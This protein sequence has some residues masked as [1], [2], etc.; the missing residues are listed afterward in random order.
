[1]RIRPLRVLI[2]D[3]NKDHQ[4]L[5]KES[6]KGSIQD[7]DI[8]FA[9]TG[10]D[11][12]H[13]LFNET[14]DLLI[15]DF[16]LSDMDGLGVLRN[17]NQKKC[18][19][20]I[21]MVTAFGNE[22]VA[23]EAMKL[24]AYD[25][26][27]KSKGYLR[28]L[29]ATILKVVREY[30]LRNEKKEIEDKLVKSELRYRTLV[31]HIIDV[32][33][34]A[35]KD[36][37][38]LSINSTCQRVFECSIEDAKK[39]GIYKLI[40][41]EDRKR[42][43][44]FFKRS[45]LNKK[46]FIEC[47][48]FRIKTGKGNIKHIELNARANYDE[49][50]ELTQIEGV[51][52]DITERKRFEQKMFQIDKLNALGLQSSGIAHEFNNILGIILGYIDILKLRFEGT[53]LQVSDVIN[54]IEKAARDGAS[55]VDKIQQ[56]SKT[57][58]K[59]SDIICSDLIKVVDE[60]IEFTMP[61]WKSEAQ[62]RGVEY[63]IIN[64]N[65][66]GQRLYVRC[67]PSELREVMVNII[68]N[69][70]DATPNGGKI[71]F[72]AK[73]DAESVV[74][75]IS[76]NGIGIRD[77]IKDKI[78]DPFFSTKG[79][80]RSGLGMSVAYSIITRY[81]GEIDVDSGCG[82]GT[83]VHIKMNSYSSDITKYEKKE[84]LTT[85]YKA[86]ILVIED[87]EVILEMMKIIL[88]KRGHEVFIAKDANDGLSMYENNKYDIVL[89]DLA[90][91]K[92]NGWKVARYIKDLDAVRKTT[93]TP[94]IL[95]TGYEL[96]TGNIDYKREGVDFILKKPLEFGLLNKMINSFIVEKQ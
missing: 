45:F 90:M 26:M 31:E 54:V 1:M 35:D 13:K 66:N 9:D 84:E 28:K 27:V 3:D 10:K 41:E 77:E 70:L 80:K 63:K 68:N 81:G 50:G 12:M 30:R 5:I 69:S 87:E 4:C 47:L 49:N 65:L 64:N 23:V 14:F 93:K 67:N 82:E 61:R 32:V 96:D 51:I 11:C 38:I 6:I 18:D 52:R 57:K 44:D 25:Y 86:K 29:P 79:V 88:E 17:V 89:C 92:V 36:L 73:S 2:A 33:F 58:P 72:S 94:V 55:I 40:Y 85:N 42:V 74:L 37:Q 83:T 43:V 16:S 21:I 34:A 78:F 71:E 24:G 22:N 19:I 76:D 59:G 75:S 48:E 8:G 7:I 39:L 56:F 46:E 62:T 91:P 60:A 95:I 53:N 20:P 15:V